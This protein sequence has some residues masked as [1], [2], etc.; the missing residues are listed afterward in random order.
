M[1]PN[2]VVLGGACLALLLQCA[3]ARAQVLVGYLLAEELGVEPFSHQATLHVGE[4]DDDGVDRARLDLR[5]KLV[6]RQHGAILRP[7]DMSR[8]GCA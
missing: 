7:V 6:Y 5:S 3:P 4:R 8:G 1:R 2:P